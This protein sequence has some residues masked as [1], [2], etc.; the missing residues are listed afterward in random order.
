MKAGRSNP[1]IL[2]PA[3]TF[4]SFSLSFSLLSSMKDRLVFWHFKEGGIAF[5]PSYRWRK[6][7]PPPLPPSFPPSRTSSHRPRRSSA[8]GTL[9]VEQEVG[10]RASDCARKSLEGREGRTGGK[11]EGR[12]RP[13]E[14]EGEV[15]GQEGAEGDGGG[16]GGG[17]SDLLAGDFTDM[18]RLS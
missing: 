10:S 18:G 1:E 12:K 7:A 16:E 14:S 2:P 9:D 3:P 5:P 15:L 11:E 6:V 4:L 17:A 13:V 8:E